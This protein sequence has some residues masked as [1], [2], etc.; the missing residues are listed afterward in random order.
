[1]PD[2][3]YDLDIAANIIRQA[4]E[5]V[6]RYYR[7]GIAFDAKPDDSPVTR[8][9]R[10]CEQ[11]IARELETAFPGDGLL[12]E[13][14]AKK[15]SATGRVWI[16]DPIDG[17]RD[18]VRG[19]PVWSNLLGLES[20]GEVVAGFVNMPAMGE[21]FSASSGAGAFVNG[22][23]MHVSSISAV[24]QAVV[25]FD[26]LTAAVRQPFGP[27]LLEWLQSF[28]AARS[29][30]G[31][32]DAMMVARGQAEIWIETSGKPWDFAPL[33]I[34]AQEAGA[35]FFD[36]QGK[37]TIYGGN[38]VVCAPPFAEIARQLVSRPGLG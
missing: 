3:Q 2:L 5:I 7:S 36:F 31:C 4:G 16:I 34:I 8:A 25:C 23:P 6:M 19:N 37:P 18:F 27:A 21:V 17:T 22:Q 13:E 1:M 33:K 30:G 28:W 14:G 9:D 29:M 32:F 10:E 35:D 12:G 11:F 24:K 15:A 26:N 38:C 20:Y